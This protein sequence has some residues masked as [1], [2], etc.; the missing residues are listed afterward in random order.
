MSK[1]LIKSQ[2]VGEKGVAAFHDYCANHNPPILWREETK[3]DFGIDGEIELVNKNE[4]GNLEVT[5]EILKVQIKSTETGSYITGNTEAS[6]EFNA[7][8]ED[9]KYWNN[10]K[11]SVILVIYFTKDEILYAK[12]IEPIDCERSKK[13]MSIIFNKKANILSKGENT[14]LPKF[15]CY[16]KGRVNYNSKEILFTNI[17]R[18]NKLPK[19]IYEYR[20][21]VSNIKDIFA[22]GI[23]PLPD[24]I[25]RS[26][27]FYSFIRLEQY[28]DF[29]KEFVDNAKPEIIHFK[30]FIRDKEK[31][32]YSI[33]LLNKYFRDHCY[34]K[35]VGF[36]KEYN[37]FYF[38]KFNEEPE[39][40]IEK[41]TYIKEVYRTNNYVP[42]ARIRASI[43]RET[44]T[45][46]TYY[47]KVDF[48][49]HFAFETFYFLDEDNL[50][51]SITPKYL[52]TSDGKNVLEDKKKVTRYTNY[53]TSKEYNQQVL[54]HI[55][56]VFQYLSDNKDVISLADYE[57]CIISISRMITFEVPF[58][59]DNDISK[60]ETIVDTE[61][62]LIQGL[63]FATDGNSTT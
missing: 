42:K 35:G 43:E 15:S 11:L 2:I 33:E 50:Y 25:L 34:K 27:Q 51:I 1:Y 29:F 41:P 3:N 20:S 17:F 9:F 54:N 31:R 59:I 19:F 55:Y 10:H 46:Y 14:F 60:N 45:R 47:N 13:R 23:N 30:S 6:F 40:K 58:S 24:F 48:Y 26:S 12:K 22:S 44:V 18:F 61:P 8:V 39:S 52:F 38:K 5:G 16:F 37:R 4:N 57:N 28:S 63:L 36:N 32:N 62:D 7:S 56:F 21:K 49:R 53:L